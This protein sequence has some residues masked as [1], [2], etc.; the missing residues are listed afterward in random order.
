MG[1]NMFGEPEI[2]VL[3]SI[4][5]EDNN[6]I[7]ES[8]NSILNQT[9]KEFEFIII[10][11]NPE[12]GRIR[13]LLD[14]YSRQ[15]N[16][17]R[18][19]ENEKNLGLQD[20]LIIGVS[21]C[22]GKYI[23]RMDADDIALPS[24]LEEQY[25]MIK[26]N[27]V[28]IVTTN[29][30]KIDLDGNII[31]EKTSLQVDGVINDKI[32]YKNR[33][34]HSSWLFNKKYIL[35]IGSYRKVKYAEDYDLLLRIISSGGTVYNIGKPLMLHRVNPAGISLANKTKQIISSI[36]V[37]KLYIERIKN[38]TNVDS[39]SFE[40]QAT[41]I[42]GYLSEYTNVDEKKSLELLSKAQEAQKKKKYLKSFLYYSSLMLRD[43]IY[44]D[45]F[46]IRLKIK[47]TS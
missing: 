18:V 2:S 6:I 46:I 40:N 7:K 44:R 16:R 38:K 33:V 45:L 8:I 15:D 41:F 19:F 1:E 12:N 28:E 17:I 9:Y 24:R 10:N 35:Q 25:K 26:K 30:N 36:Y 3:M 21:Y 39:F 5:N 37:G 23:A 43:K 29:S 20:T 32:I 47:H 34:M 14:K 13:T 42:Q 4:Y 22:R 27:G 11:D 31:K